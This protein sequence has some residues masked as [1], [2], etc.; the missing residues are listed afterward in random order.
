VSLYSNNLGV[1][2]AQSTYTTDAGGEIAAL[3]QLLDRVEL[4]VG[5]LMQADALH[6][7]RPFFSTLRSAAPTS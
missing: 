5:L 6:A 2:I 7:N 4:V 3:R 1:A